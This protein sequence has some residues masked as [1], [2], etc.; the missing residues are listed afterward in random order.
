MLKLSK[1]T[2][3]T[4]ALC[5]FATAGAVYA[6][7]NSGAESDIDY[8][9]AIPVGDDLPPFL[10][11]PCLNPGKRVTRVY[12]G[13]GGIGENAGTQ[14]VFDTMNGVKVTKFITYCVLQDLPGFVQKEIFFAEAG[15]P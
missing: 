7:A 12:D 6:T 15:N 4:V 14:P 13:A 5:A 2:V 3:G 10:S 9:T 8:G 11:E 1:V